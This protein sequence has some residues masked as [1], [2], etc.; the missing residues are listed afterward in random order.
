[1]GAPL[2]TIDAT[3]MCAHGGTAK[4]I[5]TN[6]RVKAGGAFV[7]TQACTVMI[8]GCPF[9]VPPGVPTP[10]IPAQWMVTALRVKVMGNPVIT[11]SSVGMTTGMG[12]P[13]PL[14]IVQT[15]AKVMGT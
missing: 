13:V 9:T 3:I 5:P 11:Q 10:C 2:V 4:I 14:Q 8:A 7:A 6:T 12:P 15:Q 1:M